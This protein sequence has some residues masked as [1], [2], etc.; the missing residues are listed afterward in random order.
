MAKFDPLIYEG[1]MSNMTGASS[2]AP[3]FFTPKI[4]KN[5]YGLIEYQIDG[6]IICNNPALYAFNIAMMLRKEKKIRVMS[7]GTGAKTFTPLT[8]YIDH[9]IYLTRSSEFMMNIDSYSADSFLRLY[10]KDMLQ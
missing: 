4:E 3:T 1:P 5:G 6:G 2:A 9:K 7:L 10:Y 8:R